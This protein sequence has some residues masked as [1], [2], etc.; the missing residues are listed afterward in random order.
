MPLAS[1]LAAAAILGQTPP[2]DR[3]EPRDPTV[4]LGELAAKAKQADDNIR[5]ALVGYGQARAVGLA[6]LNTEDIH[7]AQW[8]LAALF[9][10]QGDPEAARPLARIA[11]KWKDLSGRVPPDNEAIQASAES[12]QITSRN[13]RFADPALAWMRKS[14]LLM[15]E[16]SFWLFQIDWD[17]GNDELDGLLTRSLNALA[18]HVKKA[19]PGLE[20]HA[21]AIQRLAATAKLKKDAKPGAV[22]KE[23]KAYWSAFLKPGA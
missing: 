23:I 8:V 20:A 12:V 16:A 13:P 22:Q 3:T 4:W 11:E 7:R 14:G 21:A 2:D 10:R 1:L 17:S 5:T 18:E 19:P 9:V 6:S 15:G